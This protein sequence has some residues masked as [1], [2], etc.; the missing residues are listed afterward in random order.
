[1]VIVG[2]CSDTHARAGARA[3][4][5]RPQVRW[6]CFPYRTWLLRPTGPDAAAL[7][8]E[9]AN[10]LAVE[11]EVAPALPPSPSG[12]PRGPGDSGA[13]HRAHVGWCGAPLLGQ[14]PGLAD[15]LAIATGARGG[16]GQWRL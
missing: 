5:R 6:A 4:G 11:I 9:L 16:V 15:E 7:T 12:L 8:V 14:E 3:P 13:S 1:M 2:T 10:E